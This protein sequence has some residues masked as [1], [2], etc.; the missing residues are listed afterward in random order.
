MR[1]N[2]LWMIPLPKKIVTGGEEYLYELRK[3]LAEH[4][5]N[6]I[7]VKPVIHKLLI[8]RILAGLRNTFN[9]A[10]GKNSI[11]IQQVGGAGTGADEID[12]PCH[13]VTCARAP[14][15]PGNSR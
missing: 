9:P 7:P 14:A 15:R 2:I 8:I 3:K 4:G 6:V 12:R 11:L 5:F 13:R 10:I 1:R